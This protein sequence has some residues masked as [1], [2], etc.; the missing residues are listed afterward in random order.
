MPVLG[1]LLRRRGTRKK[2][3][4]SIVNIVGVIGFF[5]SF[6]VA[7][8]A[9]NFGNLVTVIGTVTAALTVAIGFGMRDQVSNLLAGLF[10]FLDSPFIRGD[11]IKT[12]ETEG[13]VQEINLR[14][15]TLNG[16]ASQKVV[17]PNSQLTMEE[18]KNYTRDVKTKSAIR[19]ELRN[20]RIEEGTDLLKELAEQRDDVLATPEP[21]IFYTD[22][23]GKIVTELHYWVD[24]PETVKQAKSELLEEFNRIA[25]SEGFFIDEASDED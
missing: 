8:Q 14:A 13:V 4:H 7:L 2:T 11:Y 9:G 5:L 16:S 1:Y 20:E 18:V 12:E 3:R 10:I 6:T 19:V 15:T 24:N 22:L 25:A 23:E 17:V 21:R